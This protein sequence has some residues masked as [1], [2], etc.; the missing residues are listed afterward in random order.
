MGVKDDVLAAMG[1]V[2]ELGSLLPAAFRKRFHLAEP[3]QYGMVRRRSTHASG[4]SCCGA[5]AP[6]A[7]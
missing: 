5:R 7:N 3:T 2:P 4:Q 1:D 6:G